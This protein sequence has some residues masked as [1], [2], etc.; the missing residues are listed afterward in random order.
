MLID[1]ERRAAADELSS[2]NMLVWTAAGF[3]YSGTECTG[4][5]REAGFRLAGGTAGRGAV[6]G[7]RAEVKQSINAGAVEH[8]GGI[9]R[10]PDGPGLGIEVDR[11]ALARFAAG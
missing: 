8:A 11:D 3:G 9:V 5:M 6:D 4:W 2:L 10:V 7:H 1:D